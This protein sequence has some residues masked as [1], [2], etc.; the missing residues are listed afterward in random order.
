MKKVLL[1]IILTISIKAIA[2]SC[3][4]SGNFIKVAP[5]SE[6][7]IKGKV[8]E[9]IY[10][11]ADGKRYLNHKKFTEAQIENEFDPHYG[12]GESI[13]IQIIEIIKGEE[14]RK[15]IEIFDT[16]GADCRVSVQEFKSG[17]TYIFSTN[18]PRRTGLKLPNETENDYAIESCYESSLEYCPEKDEVFGMI[19]GKSYKRKSIK[20]SY[21]KLKKKLKKYA[22]NKISK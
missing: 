8:L 7:I 1:L 6:L 19:K 9:H 10:H 15:F 22:H 17:K 12:I 21:Q 20:Y 3:D 14:N 11:T 5:I 4:W 2:C 13:K 18:K 16:D